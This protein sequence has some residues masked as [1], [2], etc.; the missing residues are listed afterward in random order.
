MN[1]V[2]DPQRLVTDLYL[3]ILIATKHLS[4]VTGVQLALLLSLLLKNSIYTL[5]HSLLKNLSY[6]EFKYDF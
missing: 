2:R 6:L 3:I 5:S 4:M 1:L